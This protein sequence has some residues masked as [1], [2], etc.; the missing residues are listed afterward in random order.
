M[1]RHISRTCVFLPNILW[2]QLCSALLQTLV[3][4]SCRTL[5]KILN[6]V[7]GDLSNYKPI[8]SSIYLAT[9]DQCTAFTLMVVRTS[10]ITIPETPSHR[11]LFLAWSFRVDTR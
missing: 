8:K 6:E 3:Y 2:L 11:A 9:V 10:T 5:G 7:S 1:S 4:S